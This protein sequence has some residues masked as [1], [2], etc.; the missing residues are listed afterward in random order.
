MQ[1]Q[2]PPHRRR[3]TAAEQ[4][5]QPDALCSPWPFKHCMVCNLMSNA[6][7][8]CC[9]ALYGGQARTQRQDACA[10]GLLLAKHVLAVWRA[11]QQQQLNRGACRRLIITA[12][13]TRAV[14]RPIQPCVCI[15]TV[16]VC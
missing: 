8:K 12:A 9:H 2:L 15:H 11:M 6:F 1:V 7:V 16:A 3:C 14:G 4:D 5:A 13:A 10:A